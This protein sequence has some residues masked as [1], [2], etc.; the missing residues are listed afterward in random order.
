MQKFIAKFGC[1]AHLAVLT[2]APLFL[3]PFVER[4]MLAVVMLWLS[5]PAA[6]WAILE[7]SVRGGE[8]LHNARRRVLRGMLRD[9]LLWALL[10]VVVITGVRAVNVGIALAYDA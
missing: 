2:V 7:P 8:H 1:A 4:E 6:L 10:V 3:F 9:P 5:L